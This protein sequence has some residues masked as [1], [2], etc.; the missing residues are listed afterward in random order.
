MDKRDYVKLKIGWLYDKEDELLNVYDMQE[1]FFEKGEFAIGAI[2]VANEKLFKKGMLDLPAYI[3]YTFD[4]YYNDI[5]HMDELEN[6][7]DQMADLGGKRQEDRVLKEIAY[8]M[9]TEIER[10]FGLKLP[11]DITNGR[12]VFFSSIMINRQYLPGKKI[13]R[14]IYPLNIL[15][16]RRPD[17]MLIP[18]WY[19]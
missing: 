15:R 1:E 13:D 14:R 7:A 2:V 4:E 8:A 16:G 11:E 5:N 9:E 3:I 19:W 10:I 6:I 18:H 12:E 17:A